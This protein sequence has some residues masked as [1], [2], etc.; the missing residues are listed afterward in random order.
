MLLSFTCARFAVNPDCTTLLKMYDQTYSNLL[1]FLCRKIIGLGKYVE[2]DPSLIELNPLGY[3]RRMH[4]HIPIL[5]GEH[6]NT[7]VA[8]VNICVGK[9]GA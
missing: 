4:A 8:I 6:G 1:M 5:I 9:C 7:A 2:S 3:P